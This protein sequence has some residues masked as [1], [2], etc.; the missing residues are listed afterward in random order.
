MPV[1][2]INPLTDTRWTELVDRHP[3]SSIFHTREWLRSL[4]QTYG[5]SPVAFTTS[6][7][8]E[9]ENAVVFCKVESWLTGKRLVSLPFSD[10]CQPLAEDR[11][12]EEI[13]QFV[14]EWSRKHGLKYIELRP[15]LPWDET[16]SH[17]QLGISEQFRFHSIDLR[18]SAET[19][20]RGLH[21][22]CIRRKVKRA[23]RE[24]L[25]YE[26]GNSEDLLRKFRYLLLLTRRRHK[27]P[28]QPATWFENLAASCGDK[29][30]IHMALKDQTPV[31]SILTLD[32]KNVIVYKYGCSDASQNALGGTPFLFWTVIQAAKDAG[33]V[34]L[35][36][37]RSAYDDEGLTS[38][39]EHLGGKASDLIYF[40]NPAPQ[41]TEQSA[42][43][44]I[45]SWA[46]ET[47][48][49]MPDPLLAGV[50]NL[51]YRHIG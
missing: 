16:V 25:V 3:S 10:H 32:H 39:K 18:P 34:E 7:S 41:K 17:G 19:L 44:G 4:Q 40:R 21:D 8:T 2:Q 12:L 45:S 6:N 49:R 22:S 48:S 20:Y 43:S 13:L 27:L 47:L 15:L 9:L 46:R 33:M 23:T 51:L 37:G 11:A 14:P 26:A 1:Y 24:Q 38:F 35:D 31:A 5:Y 28:P 29:L 42:G 36:L 50:G 30:R